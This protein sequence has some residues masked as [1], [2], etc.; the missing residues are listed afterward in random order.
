[1]HGG[2]PAARLLS[3]VGVV[4]LGGWRGC[5]WGWSGVGWPAGRVV[6]RGRVGQVKGWRACW[7]GLGMWTC[8]SAP[9]GV[10]TCGWEG[11]LVGGVDRCV[12]PGS[13]RGAGPNGMGAW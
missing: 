10:E 8:V 11:S 12:T 9:V 1:M 2:V 6:G 4:L 5:V 13:W 7:A 3:D